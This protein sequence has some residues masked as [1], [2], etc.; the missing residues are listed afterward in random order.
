MTCMLSKFL[1]DMRGPTGNVCCPG[2]RGGRGP[3]LE[4]SRSSWKLRPEESGCW[5]CTAN[6][7]AGT[8]DPGA[9]PRRERRVGE[10]HGGGACGCRFKGPGA[11]GGPTKPSWTP[12][13]AFPASSGARYQLPFD[14]NFL[15]GTS[16][17][18]NQR[19]TDQI[20]EKHYFQTSI[21]KHPKELSKYLL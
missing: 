21:I 3:R 17:V 18:C 4:P 15:G 20:R 2:S 7:E 11:E 5:S 14:L 9:G 19:I 8:R 12:S 13:L 1:P 16:A 6:M 10:G